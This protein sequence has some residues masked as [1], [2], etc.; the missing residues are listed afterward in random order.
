MESFD[1]LQMRDYLPVQTPP[2]SSFRLSLLLCLLLLAA[3]SLSQQGADAA[4]PVSSSQSHKDGQ[5]H[6]LDMGVLGVV[7]KCCDGPGGSCTSAW[8]MGCS[9]LRCLPWKQA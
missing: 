8:S 5:K 2:M 9:N 6:H 4:R 1:R 3:S 7:C